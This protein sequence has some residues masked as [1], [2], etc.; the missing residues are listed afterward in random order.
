MP[1]PSFVVKQMVTILMSR[2]EILPSDE[3]I[4]Q[5]KERAR[6][7]TESVE[8]DKRDFL[9]LFKG[10]FTPVRKPILYDEADGV[11]R[12]PHCMM[13]YEGGIICGQCG[14]SVD[15]DDEHYFSDEGD[16]GSLDM[17]DFDDD[18]DIDADVRFEMNRSAMLRRRARETLMA[19]H[20]HVHVHAHN[21]FL[22]HIEFGL[23][24]NHHSYD[25]ESSRDLS[26]PPSE[27]ESDDSSGPEW[28]INSVHRRRGE[29]RIL[30]DSESESDEGGEIS[31]GRRRPRGSPSPSVQ[32]VVTSSEVSDNNEATAMLE[33]AG[34]S[35]LEEHGSQ[36][37]I[38]D[39]DSEDESDTETMIGYGSETPRYESLDP[40]LGRAG[41]PG[42][43]SNEPNYGFYDFS[44]DDLDEMHGGGVTDGDG[45]TEMSS[46][47]GGEY[48][49]WR[50]NSETPGVQAEAIEARPYDYVPRESAA[51]SSSHNGYGGED[52]GAANNVHDLDN[53]SSDES[54]VPLPPRRRPRRPQSVRSQ[55]QRHSRVDATLIQRGIMSGN[56]AERNGRIH[57]LPHQEALIE[58]QERHNFGD[59]MLRRSETYRQRRPQSQ[60]YRSPFD[61]QPL[62]S[63]IGEPWL[64]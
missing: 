17:S 63:L 36:E 50:R 58:N 22:E 54:D 25:L 29:N 46:T 59:Y 14:E 62:M 51:P 26:D 7:E 40:D 11:T 23:T 28:P 48:S 13:E 5:H 57:L 37:S 2:S 49:N 30:V 6:E 20:P 12:C 33:R 19:A 56:Q 41:G 8:K 18:S 47:D 61:P 53:S 1:A 39:R 35:P 4:E 3:T 38:G 9:G 32:S 64:M 16:D 10:T 60:N 45:D 24:N 15:P 43:N 52:L 55:Q 34:W 44:S 21:A 27:S 31:R 42:F